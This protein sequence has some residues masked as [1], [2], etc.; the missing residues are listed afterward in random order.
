MLNS[1][2]RRVTASTDIT[3]VLLCLGIAVAVFLT[4]IGVNLQ[5]K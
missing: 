3:W 4:A 5:F 1:L 2:V